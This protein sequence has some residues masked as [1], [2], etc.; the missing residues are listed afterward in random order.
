MPVDDEGDE[1]VGEVGEGPPPIP[2][3][4]PPED[5][6]WRHP[7]ELAGERGRAARLRPVAAATAGSSP[8]W[9]WGLVLAAG[10]TG[11]VL[12]A[13]LIA[14]SGGVGQRI[15]ERE[16]VERVAVQPTATAT[17]A[18]PGGVVA[19]ADQLRPSIVRVEVHTGDETATGSGVVFRDSGELLTNAHVVAKAKSIDVFLADGHHV[20]GK[21]VGTDAVT[22]IAVVRLGAAPRGTKYAPALLGSATRLKVGQPVIA[23]GSPLGLVGG[24]SVSTGVISA[25]GRRIDTPGGE[26]LHDLIQ[27]DAPIARGSSGGALVDASGAVVGI[28]TALAVA[29]DGSQFGFAVPI[30]VARKVADDIIATGKAAHVW[31]GVEG[32]D[33]AMDDADVL[34]LD[35]GAVLRK[36]L[37][38][39]PALAA[40]LAPG[41]IVVALDG[42]AVMSMSGL[43]VALRSHDPGEKVDVTYM[44]DGR[45]STVTLTLASRPAT[46]PK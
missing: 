3:L 16:V 39:G 25:L 44:R 13:G 4:L 41:D 6:L 37:N 24:P 35:G 8:G 40:G 2:P 32:A 20:A 28:T 17:A 30:D 11:S 10:L 14:L 42:Q 15:I 7:S 43:I 23:I 9:W 31:L 5:R 26:P 38:P 22:D 12:T 1:D 34:K 46:P 27:T 19:V 36:V 33:L 29:T 45:R 21:V 18:D